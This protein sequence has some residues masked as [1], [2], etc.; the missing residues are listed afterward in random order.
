MSGVQ[1]ALR[2][3]LRVIRWS[4][5]TIFTG[6][7]LIFAGFFTAMAGKILGIES[8]N[9]STAVVFTGFGLIIFGLSWISFKG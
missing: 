5:V 7:Y 8:I 9:Y 2:K 1:V 3:V 4:R 6:I